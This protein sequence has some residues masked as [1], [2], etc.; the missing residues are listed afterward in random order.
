MA[1]FT[2]LVAETT[3]Y[4]LQMSE[5]GNSLFSC[6]SKVK[7][8]LFELLWKHKGIGGTAPL[9][10]NLNSSWRWVVSFMTRSLYPGGKYQRCLLNRRKAVLQ[11]QFL[12]LWRKRK[13]L[14]SAGNRMLIPHI[15]WFVLTMA[16][17]LHTAVFRIYGLSQWWA[18]YGPRARYGPLKCSIRPAR[19]Y[20]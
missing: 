2:F 8:L 4:F 10:L 12:T 9:I 1:F 19:H 6:I 7:L 3:N 17:A 20:S 18:N 14:A 15:V 13:S 16:S 11:G 5:D